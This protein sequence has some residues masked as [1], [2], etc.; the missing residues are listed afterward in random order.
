V[1]WGAKGDI[2]RMRGEVGMGWCL[3]KDED[4]GMEA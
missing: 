3:L 4:G 1:G 2:E